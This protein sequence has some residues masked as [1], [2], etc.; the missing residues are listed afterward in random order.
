MNFRDALTAKRELSIT[1]GTIVQ[2]NRNEI[3]NK[4][5]FIHSKIFYNRFVTSLLAGSLTK[6]V[7][8]CG[9]ETPQASHLFLGFHSL[10]A[11]NGTLIDSSMSVCPSVC[12]SHFVPKL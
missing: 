8:L 5:L 1:I 9:E 4:N 11:K 3:R 7:F 2:I 12:H 6:C 10:L